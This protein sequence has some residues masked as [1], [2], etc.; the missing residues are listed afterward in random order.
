[1]AVASFWRTIDGDDAVTLRLK[2]AP[3][4][5]YA[6]VAQPTAQGRGRFGRPNA[7]LSGLISPLLGRRVSLRFRL[8]CS[9]RD[10][11]AFALES[12]EAVPTDLFNLIEFAGDLGAE[13]LQIDADGERYEQLPFFE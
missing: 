8:V 2:G 1:M 11:R 5:T 3:Q 4:Q 9:R 7:P 13:W 10:L 6:A 12:V